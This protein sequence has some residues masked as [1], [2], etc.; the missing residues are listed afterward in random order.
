MDATGLAE[1]WAVGWGPCSAYAVAGQLLAGSLHHREYCPS[2]R[3]AHTVVH[4]LGQTLPPE[5]HD[6]INKG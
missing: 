4:A 5:Q 2:G 6:S 1:R 3:P